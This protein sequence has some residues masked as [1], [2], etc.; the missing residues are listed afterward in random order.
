GRG[1]H[2]AP[3]QLLGWA[4][5]DPLRDVVMR[6]AERGLRRLVTKALA[7]TPRGFVPRDVLR[8]TSLSGQLQVEW[9]TRDI[10]PWDRILPAARQAV[11]FRE[12]T[13]H[14]T[15]AAVVRLFRMLP[16][17]DVMD[18]RVLEPHFPDRLLLAGTVG[19][20]DVIAAQSLSS[21]G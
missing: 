4:I 18:V 8:L 1:A 21:P 10:H 14:D 6:L 19:R 16:E 13:L 3:P 20:E 15:D 9:Q 12:Q 11:M 17:I 2:C 5:P 7:L